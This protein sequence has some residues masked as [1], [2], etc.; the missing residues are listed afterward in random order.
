MPATD[1]LACGAPGIPARWTS[2]AKSGVGTALAPGCRLW[3]TISHG[4][5]NEVYHPRVDSACTRDLGL[6][7]TGPDGYFSEEKR[8]ADHRVAQFEDG[9]P[10]Y[11]LTNTSR[12]GRYRIVKRIVVD[13]LRPVLL[14]EIEFLAL[15]GAPADYHVFALL[16]P[17]LVNAGMGNTAWIGDYKGTPMLF[18]RGKSGASLALASS[19]PWVSASAGYVGFSDG[20]QQLRRAGRLDPSCRRAEHGNVA[21]CGEIG[22]SGAG[23]RAVLALGFGPTPSEAG[24]NVL[25]SLNGGFES[26]TRSYVGGWRDWQGKL[27]RLDASVH[28]RPGAYR[29]S[30]AVLAAHRSLAFPG[31]AVASLSIPWG[32]S[33]GDDD[34]GGY[35][36]VWPRDLVET[37]G[38]FLAA[39]DHES[40][41]RI[42]AHLQTIQEAD[43]HWPQNAWLDGQAYWSGIQMDECA[44]PILLAD[45]LFRQ[46]VL[47][48]SDLSTFLPMIERAASYI[49]LHGP[50]TGQD[51]W[52][53]DAGYS[54]FTLA[55]EIAALLAAADLVEKLGNADGA[56]YLR[57][58][59][60][61]WNDQV[62]R[63]TFVS[64]TDICRDTGVDGYYV[65]ISAPDTSD[66]A[67]PR[68]GFVP[69]KNRPPAAV[70]LP[71]IHII[72]PDALA[73]VRFGLRAADDP[74][75]ID[76]VR[77]IDRS[78]RCELPQGPLWYR[79]TGD[80]YGEH[81]DGRPF[82]G[83]GHGKPWPL[84]VGERAHYEL[85]AG[86]RDEAE[87]LLATLEQSAGKGGLL[88]EQVWDGPDIPERQ[89]YLGHPSGS[90]MPLVWAHSEH[91]KLLRSLRDGAVF[92]MPPQGVQRYIRDRTVSPFRT[93]QFVNKIR[94]IPAG[95]ILRIEAA[96][97]AIIHWSLDGWKTV[98]DSETAG[99]CFGVYHVDLPVEQARVGDQVQ[100]TFFWTG[101]GHWEGVDF[102][103]RIDA[104]E[105]A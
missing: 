97:S 46:G 57:E 43:G 53:E 76:T 98:H 104:T 35:H 58:T 92:D 10:A 52:E 17:H 18:A 99:N 20:W 68:G 78:I 45:L 61:T 2:S 42:L 36:L 23:S 55:V 39:G 87:R 100:F 48:L 16:A 86:R 73:L 7:V 80:G 3:F 84:L 94:S 65:R 64:G 6:V 28:S 24:Y 13:S 82:D 9:V 19:L 95:K 91:I 41:R 14:Q 71:A 70:G 22:F 49:V 15:S 81:R 96:A 56:R 1:G 103:V 30:T 44:F 50:V 37:A 59:A 33:K 25:A 27:E 102:S 85:A 72:S 74:R 4:I 83:T 8:D 12:D 88:P 101:A 90:A 105:S 5:L 21:L 89:L 38:G 66:A 54:P 77:I 40:A 69:I 63:W 26:A 47:P 31:A 67:S 93:W 79:Y 34:I 32:F 62:E 11:H 60:D 75:I 29:T 51:R